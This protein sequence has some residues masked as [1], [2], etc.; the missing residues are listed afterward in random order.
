MNID[1]SSYTE[2][3]L[4]EM[5]RLIDEELKNRKKTN[6]QFT[7]N[8]GE[9][10]HTDI[11]T[12]KGVNCCE[13][14]GSVINKDYP[15]FV[16]ETQLPMTYNGNLGAN[17]DDLYNKLYSF[18]ISLEGIDKHYYRLKFNYSG[19]CP[20]SRTSIFTGEFYDE[21]GNNVYSK[22]FY[23]ER[24]KYLKETTISNTMIELPFIPG[25]VYTIKLSSYYLESY[26]F[27][28]SIGRI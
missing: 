27:Y 8:C 2:S 1:L 11:D 9:G 12:N 16:I 14:C 20:F 21:D 3:S 26:Q 15:G 19:E 5:R 22:D 25:K 28:K 24:N 6:L 4:I 18:I 7:K 17:I 23:C 13:V 10:N